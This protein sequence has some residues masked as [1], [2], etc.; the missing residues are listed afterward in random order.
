MPKSRFKQ[1]C[2]PWKNHCIVSSCFIMEVFAD[3]SH[4]GKEASEL[5]KKSTATLQSVNTES[6]YRSHPLYRTQKNVLVIC[7]SIMNEHNM[8]QKTSQPL[9]SDLPHRTWKRDANTMDDMI[10][11]GR[12]AA[13]GVAQC[14]VFPDQNSAV[15][16]NVDESKL[17]DSGRLALDL[18][19]SSRKS[20]DGETWGATAKAQV[21][22]I[23][24]LLKVIPESITM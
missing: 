23:G 17:N 2:K 7:H 14:I 9:K 13:E 19:E 5:K 1:T 24:G 6:S 4:S 18:L 20:L 15:V 16:R 22:A 21:S 8:A 3:C 10:E 11:Y 12:R